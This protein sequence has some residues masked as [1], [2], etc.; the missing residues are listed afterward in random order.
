MNLKEIEFNLQF[1]L[2]KNNGL[3]DKFEGKIKFPSFNLTPK[4]GP[5]RLFRPTLVGEISEGEIIK[6]KIM[7]SPSYILKFLAYG[8]PFFYVIIGFFL[9]FI[10]LDININI[11][12]HIEFYP[13]IVAIVTFIIFKA[14]FEVQYQY[15]S[16][17]IIHY[18]DLE[19]IN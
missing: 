14:V 8:M 2:E 3:K 10:G 19:L 13:A 16:K 17:V 12:C 6:V 4:L 9:Y 5:R 7:Y 15:Y 1:L 18:L 11:F